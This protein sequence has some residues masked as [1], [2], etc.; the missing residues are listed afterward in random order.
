MDWALFLQ[1]QSQ[2]GA[3]KIRKTVEVI[4]VAATACNKYALID[5]CVSAQI[6]LK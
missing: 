4:R 5:G 1:P 6:T 3:N 2:C